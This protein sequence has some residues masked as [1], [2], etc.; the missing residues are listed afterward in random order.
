[1]H[2]FK[3][4]RKK[5]IFSDMEKYVKK[6]VEYF[7]VTT[8]GKIKFTSPYADVDLNQILDKL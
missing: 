6:L 7:K 3:T 8:L 1:M 5:K 2:D 4:M